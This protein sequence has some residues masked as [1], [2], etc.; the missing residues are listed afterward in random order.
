MKC[1]VCGE[2]CVQYAHQILDTLDTVFAPCPACKPQV[3]DKEK[4]PPPGR[5]NAPVC[6]CEKRFID[7]VFVD[8]Y[9]VMVEEGL[10]S[11]GSP[12][13]ETGIPLVHPGFAMT[14][15]PYLPRNSLLLLSRHVDRETA[16]R[17]MRE[18]P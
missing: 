11:H 3:L 16:E 6:T 10:L 1:P 17:L 13:R 15:P 18:I 4:P 2:D 14:Q 12:L 7:N 8:I 9:T 5:G